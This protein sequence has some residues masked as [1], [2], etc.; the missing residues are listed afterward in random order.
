M[1]MLDRAVGTGFGLVRALVLLGGFS[2]LFNMATPRETAPGW[3]TGAVLYPLT[4]ASGRDSQG[5]R[6]ERP[7]G[8][9]NRGAEAGKGRARRRRGARARR[10]GL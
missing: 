7:G 5:F 9:E 8:R 3:V 6:A 10:K 1:G 2:L 4:E